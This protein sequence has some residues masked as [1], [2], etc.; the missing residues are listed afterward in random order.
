MCVSSHLLSMAQLQWQC[1]ESSGS[2]ALPYVGDLPMDFTQHHEGTPMYKNNTS[3]TYKVTT[4]PNHC[5]TVFIG[6]TMTE[7][8]PGSCDPNYPNQDVLTVSQRGLPVD[9]YCGVW[10]YASFARTSRLLGEGVEMSWAANASPSQNE[11]GIFLIITEGG[12][13]DCGFSG[14]LLS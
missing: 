13:S 8:T 11:R 7:G 2:H 3:C 1:T 12:S 4:D 14:K 5:V 10:V 6:Y 9:Y